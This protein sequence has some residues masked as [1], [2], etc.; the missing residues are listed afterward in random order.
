MPC[1]DVPLVQ[2][3]LRR[4]ID[5][6]RLLHDEHP[7]PTD[8]LLTLFAAEVDTPSDYLFESDHWGD[9]C[10]AGVQLAGLADQ[11]RAALTAENC[12]DILHLDAGRVMAFVP[13]QIIGERLQKA[14]ERLAPIKTGMVTISTICHVF[15]VR[16]LVEG[17]Y[18]APTHVIG[19]PGVNSYQGRVNRYFGVESQSTIPTPAQIAARHHFGEVIALTDQLLQRA[20]ESRLIRPF[21]ERLPFAER[22]ESCQIRPAERLLENIPICGICQ[23]KR[24]AAPNTESYSALIMVRVPSLS[25]LRRSQRTPAAYRR[26]LTAY[27]TAFGRAIERSGARCLWVSGDT[28][29]LAARAETALESVTRLMTTLI[30]LTRDTSL[31]FSVGIGAGNA[32]PQ[33]LLKLANSA[34]ADALRSPEPNRIALRFLDAARFESPSYTMDMVERLQSAARRFIS[35]RFPTDAFPDLSLQIA[36]GTASLYYVYGRTRLDESHRRLLDGLED[37]WGKDTMRFYHA[38]DD[39]I[40]LQMAAVGSGERT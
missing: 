25:K 15:T 23:R 28:A 32:E 16:Q 12:R 22:C 17:L 30:D 35:A 2:S 6:Q 4:M 33:T 18:R 36:R 14:V 27:E 29:L 3:I 7:T 31:P 5:L 19:I 38:L 1:A 8:D 34:A 11:F 37:E 21:Y 20:R 9:V 24:S 13:D 10:G 26:L 39:L 40:N